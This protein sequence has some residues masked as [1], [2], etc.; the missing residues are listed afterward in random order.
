MDAMG[1]LSDFERQTIRAAFAKRGPGG[2][3]ADPA[4]LLAQGPAEVTVVEQAPRKH[5]CIFLYV[6]TYCVRIV[7]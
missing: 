6:Y 2:A 3:P 1:G 7:I 5:L 4:A